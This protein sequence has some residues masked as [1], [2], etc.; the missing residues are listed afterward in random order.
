MS[1]QRKSPD[2]YPRPARASPANG[3]AAKGVRSGTFLS[4]VPY[5]QNGHGIRAGNPIDDDVGRHRDQFAG[6]RLTARPAAAGEHRQTVAGKQKLA[7]DPSGR[8]RVI[9]RD[10]AN[11]STD[12]SQRSG[13]PDNGQRS[14]RLGGRGVELAFREPQQPSA[15]RFVR[16]CSRVRV[17]LGDGR[18]ESA[19]FGFVILDQWGWRCHMESMAYWWPGCTSD[20]KR[21]DRGSQLV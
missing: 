3:S 17:R 4:G 19:A 14:A 13:T 18:R 2:A 15:N 5:A 9:G 1:R 20:R 16:H 8:D 12:I 7:P 21:K 11:D 6:F 10:I